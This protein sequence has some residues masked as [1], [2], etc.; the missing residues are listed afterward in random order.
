M[1]HVKPHT[2]HKQRGAL[3]FAFLPIL[4]GASLVL[5]PHTQSKRLQEI[6]HATILAEAKTALIAYAQSQPYLVNAGR[7]KGAPFLPCPVRTSSYEG[8]AGGSCGSALKPQVGKL[9]WRTLNT[10]PLTN[11]YGD[12]VWYV[13][14]GNAKYQRNNRS[15]FNSDAREWLTYDNDMGIAAILFPNQQAAK[16][17]AT[18]HYLCGTSHAFE[19]FFDPSAHSL[20]DAPK[21]AT[22]TI[23]AHLSAVLVKKSDVFENYTNHPRF[24]KHNQQLAHAL[25]LCWYELWQNSKK[26]YPTP[27]AL[28]DTRRY[29]DYV[30]DE[31]LRYGRVPINSLEDAAE[32]C[33]T[34]NMSSERLFVQNHGFHWK[35]H[36]FMTMAETCIE[37][38]DTCLVIQELACF[39]VFA[40]A[41]EPLE[42]QARKPS[43][44]IG[45]YLEAP[46]LRL[47]GANN[48]QSVANSNDQA[49]CLQP[50]GALTAMTLSR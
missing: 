30:S 20:L 17:A 27:I 29:N 14:A 45:D 49:Y 33:E 2:R 44:W 42:G 48:N 34:L 32:D 23:P 22:I 15:H 21:D 47:W 18:R 13:V 4:L 3:W 24:S 43:R 10:T 35:S 16:G 50:D 46:L 8:S 40:F 6:S 36:W 41:G 25:A 26:L 38:Q 28:D 12:C 11:P 9:P 39:A 1:F 19:A 7:Q 31:A 5:A 37:T